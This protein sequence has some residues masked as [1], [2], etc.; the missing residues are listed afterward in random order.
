MKDVWL[1]ATA[2]RH[3]DFIIIRKPSID[4]ADLR[5]NLD[6][7]F[8]AGYVS[9][10]GQKENIPL[11]YTFTETR[12]GPIKNISVRVRDGEVPFRK[13]LTK[14]RVPDPL[15]KDILTFAGISP[16]VF[17]DVARK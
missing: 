3:E 11:Y 5:V 2:S 6:E 8:P 14:A 12:V 10:L 13:S 4:F 1:T 7:F 16:F 15:R 17:K 9:M